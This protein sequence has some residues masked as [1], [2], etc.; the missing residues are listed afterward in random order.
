MKCKALQSV[1]TSSTDEQ[2]KSNKTTA[3]PPPLGVN[4][5]STDEVYKSN[6]TTAAPHPLEV[7]RQWFCCSYLSLLE[8]VRQW[9]CC[10]YSSRPC[11]K[12]SLA[13][14]DPPY[15]MLHSVLQGTANICTIV[16]P[17]IS[18]HFGSFL[19]DVYLCRCWQCFRVRCA[20]CCMADRPLEVV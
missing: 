8:V 9:F 16:C 12:C 11:W 6:K 5:S 15:S 14:A 17:P 7:V 1:N 10:S 20:A 2:N 18:F 19:V 13:E 3:A 4:T